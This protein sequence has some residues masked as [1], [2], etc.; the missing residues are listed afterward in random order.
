MM[1]ALRAPSTCIGFSLSLAG[2][3]IPALLRRW[4]LFALSV[5]KKDPRGMAEAA[6]VLL[7][8][9]AITNVLTSSINVSIRCSRRS[10][11]VSP[12]G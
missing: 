5:S 4:N 1:S 3:G 12:W 8:P 2:N 6:L 10:V 9:K 11:L 7:W